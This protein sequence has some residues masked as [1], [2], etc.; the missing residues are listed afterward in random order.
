MPKRC[1]LMRVSLWAKDIP[2]E[3]HLVYG[4]VLLCISTCDVFTDSPS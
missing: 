1:V 4:D 2:K 3:I